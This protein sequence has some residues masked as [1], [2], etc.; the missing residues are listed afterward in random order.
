MWL[1][2]AR[3]RES[4]LPNEAGPNRKQEMRELPRRTRV[5]EP[6]VSDQ[7]RG[8]SQGE[9][10]IRY[11]T[12]LP[13]CRGV[14]RNDRPTGN[15]SN[16]YAEEQAQPS[17]CT[18]ADGTDHQGPVTDWT[19]TK[20]EQRWQCCRHNRTREND[21]TSDT[22]WQPATSKKHHTYPEGARGG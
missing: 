7:E 16:F 18:C 13:P 12:L 11:T 22:R 9:G 5:V 8:E 19:R 10:P 1:L 3:T 2:C 15:T 6:P 4:G 17:R 21:A 14:I 20:E